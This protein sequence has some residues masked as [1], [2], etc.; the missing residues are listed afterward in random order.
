MLHE[1]KKI[2]IIIFVLSVATT[3]C[4]KDF[5]CI[6]GNGIVETQERNASAFNII[7]NSTAVDVI[8]KKDDSPGLT[9]VAES[10]LLE[11]I[12]TEIVNGRLE[13]RTDPRATC[14]DYTIQPVI[15]VTSPELKSIESS[16]SGA[17][18]ADTLSGNTNTIKLSGSGDIFV[19]SVSCND[20]SL[21]LYGSG[22]MEI[23]T[24]SCQEADILITGSGDI[25]IKGSSNT[26]HLRITGS[27]D[28]KS[29]QFTL[30][31]ANETISGSGNIHTW[32]ENSLT[33][34]ISGSGNIYLKGNPVINQ[35]ITGSGKIIKN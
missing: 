20:L 10:N 14:L 27:G 16:G 34:S 6:N 17:F 33:A 12:V 24:G 3:S 18:I 26:G 19:K 25:D 15:M 5:N 8:F 13:I 35:T 29:G 2:H 9:V 21:T 32:V 4:I 1:M 28:I 11:H 22:D 30:V 23:A 7:E 31:T